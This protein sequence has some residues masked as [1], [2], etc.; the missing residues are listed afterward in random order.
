M[1]RT[2][3]IYFA[4]IT[5]IQSSSVAESSSVSKHT[6]NPALT[7]LLEARMQLLSSQ[8]SS[9]EIVQ[10]VRDA[11]TEHQNITESKIKE[12]DTR[13]T[14]AKGIDQNIKPYLT[15]NCAKKLVEFQG[16]NDEFAEIFLT[17]THGLNVCQTNK[18]S[19][20]YQADEAWWADTWNEGDGHAH[21]G[22]I[23]YD[24]SARTEAIPIYSPVYDPDSKKVIGVA[25]AV[26]DLNSIKDSI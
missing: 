7:R 14:E 10:A 13:W 24:Q 17:D 11:N 2:V 26:L 18:T 8:L 9:S 12:L 25:K 15:N 5:S 19:D 1:L 20:L 23:E 16:K 21:F 4:V 6:P 22:Q 3:I